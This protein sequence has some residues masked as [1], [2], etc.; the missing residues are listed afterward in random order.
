[1]IKG[2]LYDALESF[3]DEIRI[4][5]EL[6]NGNLVSVKQARYGADARYEGMLI[7]TTGRPVKEIK[8][9]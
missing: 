1:M 6:P 8:R 3:T 4:V 7:L 9:P 2:D 5:V